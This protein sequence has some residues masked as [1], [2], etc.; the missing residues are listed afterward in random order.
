MSN[1]TNTNPPEPGKAAGTISTNNIQ[2]FLKFNCSAIDSAT[3]LEQIIDFCITVAANNEEWKPEI[4]S[5]HILN[6]QRWRNLLLLTA[7]EN[8]EDITGKMAKYI[9][10]SL[11]FD[12]EPET[13]EP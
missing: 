8:G 12:E 13:Q 3:D 5:R 10:H 2:E 11:C 6:L 4:I 9:M 1:T 7:I